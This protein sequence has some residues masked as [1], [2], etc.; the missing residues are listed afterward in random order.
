MTLNPLA[1]IDPIGTLL[2]PGI[3]A[4]S[5]GLSLIGWA[6]PVPVSPYRFSRNVTMHRGLLLTALAGPASNI[7]LA[8]VVSGVAMALF[9]DDLDT[10][11]SRGVT[12]SRF[13]SLVAMSDIGFVT[14]NEQ[15]LAALG[16]PKPQAVALMFMSKLVLLNVGLA[17][18]NMIPLPPLDGSR[19]LPLS[20][21]ES[22]SRYTMFVFI[23]LLVLI[24]TAG[25]LLAVPLVPIVEAMLGFWGLIF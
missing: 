7:V 16:L 8:L 5:G 6:K 18:F 25:G 20:V 12:S 15:S 11:I 9:G 22:L 4:V 23:G 17:I 10:L 3:S 14:S 13:W 19:L 1:H 21:Q 2:L 24:N